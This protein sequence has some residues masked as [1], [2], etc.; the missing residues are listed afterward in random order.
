M[1][2][3]KSI[4]PGAEAAEAWFTG[5]VTVVPEK[6]EVDTTDV[7]ILCHRLDRAR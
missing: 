4:R 5:A 7:S 1:S 6:N 2:K 3:K